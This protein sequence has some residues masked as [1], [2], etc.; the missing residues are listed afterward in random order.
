[1][2][3][4]VGLDSIRWEADT[5]QIKYYRNSNWSLE[6]TQYD[7]ING[8]TLIRSKPPYCLTADDIGGQD[9]P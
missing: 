7:S 8:D 4:I 3:Y 2:N 9:C 1:M 5:G 6:R